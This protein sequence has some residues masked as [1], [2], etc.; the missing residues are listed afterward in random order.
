RVGGGRRLFGPV[1][2]ILPWGQPRAPAGLRCTL[3][4]ISAGP[5]EDLSIAVRGGVGDTPPT[6]YLDGNAQLYDAAT[7]TEIGAR[8]RD[9]WTAIVT[10]LQRA[11]TPGSTPSEPP[12]PDVLDAFRSHVE[13]T[14]EAIAI[15]DGDTALTYAELD[16]RARVV[17]ARLR[18]AGVVPESLVAIDLPRGA[19][20]IAAMLGALR[21]GA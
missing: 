10:G 14:P 21:L 18:D 2:N 17:E 1:L 16:R 3:H 7:L 4:P 12:P 19:T 8:L 20:A 15:E 5:A 6:R 9:T 11:P 13:R